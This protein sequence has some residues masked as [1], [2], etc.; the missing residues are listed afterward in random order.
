[1]G[2]A[3]G[4][5]EKW[6]AAITPVFLER[7]TAQRLGTHPSLRGLFSEEPQEEATSQQPGPARVQGKVTLHGEG[8]GDLAADQPTAI[9]SVGEGVEGHCLLF[10]RSRETENAPA[11][12]RFCSC[13]GI[14]GKC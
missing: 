9:R 7:H 3:A 12:L 8:G 11:N 13:L 1:M 14:F 10:L 2:V 6:L 4:N 5:S